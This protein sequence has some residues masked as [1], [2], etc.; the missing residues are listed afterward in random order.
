[1]RHKLMIF[2]VICLLLLLFFNLSVAASTA[3]DNNTLEIIDPQM[4]F[5]EEGEESVNPASLSLSI[6]SDILDLAGRGI[7]FKLTRIKMLAG[8]DYPLRIN[9][10]WCFGGIPVYFDRKLILTDGRVFDFDIDSAGKVDCGDIIV[11]RDPDGVI[12]F[13]NG[14][15]I[16]LVDRSQWRQKII[17]PNGNAI[18]VAFA[19]IEDGN[20]GTARWRLSSIK[21]SIG[22]E[23]RFKFTPSQWCLCFGV[24]QTMRDGAKKDILN[25]DYNGDNTQVVDGFYFE[26]D[27]SF[28]DAG[29]R[30]T[31]YAW[32]SESDYKITYPNGCVSEYLLSNL[33]ITNHNIYQ[34]GANSPERTTIYRGT[35]QYGDFFKNVTV[36]D[37]TNIKKYIFRCGYVVSEATYDISAS[38]L[39][40]K[41]I[42]AY[43]YL[44]DPR[45]SGHYNAYPTVI[46]RYSTDSNGNLNSVP[47]TYNYTYDAYHNITSIT[48]PYGAQT[49]MSYANSDF[50]ITKA[51]KEATVKVSGMI[52]LTPESIFKMKYGEDK[53]ILNITNI[54]LDDS[55]LTE[56]YKVT[57][58]D[59]AVASGCQPPLYQAG[60]GYHQMTAQ[61]T[62]VKDPVNNTAQ[63]RQTH[64]NYDKT[65]GNLLQKSEVYDDGYLHTYYTYD[66]Y[67][68]M[69]TKTDAN[70]NKLGYE[71]ADTAAKPYESAYLTRVYNRDGTT[72]ATYDYDF[73]TGTK[74]M[75]TDPKGNIFRY[76]YDAGGRLTKEWQDNPD[77]NLGIARIITYD[78][79]NSTVALKFGNA[80]AGWQEGL[81]RYDPIFGGP[82]VLQR[83]INGA[84]VTQKELAYDPKGRLASEQDAMRHKTTY[85]Y[86]ELDR[87]T[88][89]TRP[90]GS[91]TQLAYDGRT[92]ITTDAKG[93][94][95][96]QTYD[97]LDRLVTV[98]ESPDKGKTCYTTTYA[99]DSFYDYFRA[100][101]VYHLVKTVNPQ[102]AAII[103]TFDNLG[104]LIRTNY[105]QDGSNPITAAT[106]LYDNVGNLKTKTDAK[107]CK[108]F[109]YEY[110]AGYRLKTVT[111][112]DKRTVV[113]TYDANDNPLTQTVNDVNYTYAYDA[114]N[115]VTDLTAKLDGITFLVKYD[116]DTFGR[117]TGIT[118][119][120][121]TNPVKY[122]YDELDR[123]TAIPGFV[124]SCS[125]D[126][127]NKLTEMVYGNAVANTFTY[128]QNDRLTTISAGNL[129]GLTYDYDAVGNIA[130]INND[131]YDYDGLNRLIWYGDQP[132]TNGT[133][134]S[135]DGA[136]NISGK[137]VYL[138][139]A[140][141]GE[142]SFSYDLANRLWAQGATTYNNDAA[143]VRTAKAENGDT[144]SYV[145]DG[146]SRL[147]KVTRN[148]ATLV[149][150]VYDSIG[151]RYRKVENGK[152]TYYIYN[153]TD[154]LIEYTPADGGY[155]YRI[156]AGKRAIAEERAGVVKFYHKDHL[157]STRVVTD[158]SGKKV[159][160]YKYAP[161]GKKEI[162][163]GSGTD[164][165]FT[166]KSYEESLGLSYFGARFY[167]QEAGRFITV[168]PA[169]DG[170]NWYAYCY[171]NPL[172]Y[173]D[174]DGR[175]PHV[176]V[177][178]GL[179]FVVGIASRFM[180]D[181]TSGEFSSFGTYM[182]YGGISAA[183]FALASVGNMPAAAAAIKAWQAEEVFRPL[184]IGMM[185]GTVEGIREKVIAAVNGSS[186]GSESSSDDG[187]QLPKG[188]VTVGPGEWGIPDENGNIDWRSLP[189]GDSGA[190][191]DGPEGSD[192]K[193]TIICTELFRQ[194]LMS[195]KIYQADQAFGKHLD[196]EYPLVLKGYYLWARPVVRNMRRSR[197]FTAVVHSIAKPWYLEMAHMTDKG[198]KGSFSGKI[199]MAIGIP[200]CWTIGFAISHKLLVT[201]LAVCFIV[202][203]LRQKYQARNKIAAGWQ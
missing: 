111:E 49:L 87:K 9:R 102:N 138:K 59:P 80:A 133:R 140:S 13:S 64:F 181:V 159:A 156:Y 120:G 74:T 126:S 193:G 173:R 76:E 162:A 125:Y 160:E 151:M 57:Y 121:R 134:W 62:L 103:N 54:A 91:T 27:L 155:T 106:F 46:S 61:A 182:W 168:D 175:M 88:L 183:G 201:V 75:A 124:N 118:Y 153:G 2:P 171:N 188:K 197:L 79:V 22:R 119:P 48:G 144:W 127:D 63:L 60:I 149:E 107:G 65:T 129:L 5:I 55:T 101:P 69:V 195:K 199:I 128:D 70:G 164:Y 39:R 146:G 81:I 194:G 191:D 23:F 11:E 58:Q 170:I 38:T 7:N 177:I 131:Y 172:K 1:M 45:K 203:M 198:F 110:F 94:K 52:V 105:P 8:P 35:D 108:T 147:T 12:K 85:Q 18:E 184:L 10:G 189:D 34:K 93:N 180:Q 99:Y 21:D 132:Q 150:N 137:A 30:T 123:L 97:L 42:K 98:A 114:R 56:T 100:K 187:N 47:A 176:V 26:K 154:P 178:G 142:T 179:G 32:D 66:S 152:T 86:D 68:N 157:G 6:E 20:S 186:G 19:K 141:Q 72:I 174:A 82:T 15:K 163:I 139:G 169:C 122:S 136:G 148:A 28:T 41:I 67:G 51:V 24:T 14:L 190:G 116:Y 109:S 17:D 165:Q 71:Y 16:V 161:Y 200:L 31:N 158:A 115:R 185:S 40:E 50:D 36:N 89:I 96:E 145:Y 90:D 3:E 53:I 84:W 167:D 73:D 135:Y 33:K 117:V 143:G 113:Y 43:T 104:R 29:G 77:S 92:V 78:D 4:D 130:Q 192:S 83:K 95:R 25:I 196:E 112:P 166:D 37:G 202:L 44:K